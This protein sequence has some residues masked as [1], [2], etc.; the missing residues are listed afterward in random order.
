MF[1]IMDGSCQD[2]CF[3]VLNGINF[4]DLFNESDVVLV[5]VINMADK[6]GKV[7]CI[8]FS[9]QDCLASRKD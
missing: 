6:R 4:S 7:S 2:F 3:V 9:S 5:D 8:S 1:G